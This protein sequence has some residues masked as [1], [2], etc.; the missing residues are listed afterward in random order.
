M[1]KQL[2]ASDNCELDF[3]YNADGKYQVYKRGVYDANVWPRIR[4]PITRGEIVASFDNEAEAR[5]VFESLT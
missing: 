5:K 3:N 2:A 1:Y 4:V